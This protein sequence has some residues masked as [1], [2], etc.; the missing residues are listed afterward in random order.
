MNGFRGLIAFSAGFTLAALGGALE[1]VRSPLSAQNQ[2]SLGAELSWSE[3][4]RVGLGARGDLRLTPTVRAYL[5]GVYYFPDASRLVESSAD[6]HRKRVELN[7]NVVRE[8]ER[9]G[10]WLYLGGGVSWEWRTL[11]IRFEGLE[12]TVS[13]SGWAANALLGIRR[14]GPGVVPHV[15]V[16]RELWRFGWWVGTVGVSVPVP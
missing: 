9:W 6:A 12:E 16:K 2:T 8:P 11:D 10:G 3:G 7:L 15:E 1:G 14:P 4:R 13:N 5:Q